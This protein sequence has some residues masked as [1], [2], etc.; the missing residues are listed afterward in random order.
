[1]VVCMNVA[2]YLRQSF[3]RY[4]DELAVTRQLEDCEKLA[5]KLGKVVDVYEDNDTSAS[6]RDV[7]RPEYNRLL[8][9]FEDGR[10]TALVCWDLDRLTRQPRQLEDW[11]D[12]AEERGLKLVTAN[13]EADLS[14]DGGRMYAR[15]KAAVAR[16]EIERKSKRQVSRYQQDASRGVHHWTTRPFGYELDGTLREA[17]ADAVKKAFTDTLA[18]VTRSE[19]AREWNAAGFVGPRDGRPWKPEGVRFQLRAARN[20]G[21]REYKGK[22][23]G[24]GTWTAVVDVDTWRG[25]QAVL[26]GATA[27]RTGGREFTTLLSHLATCAKCGGKVMGGARDK[28][29][30]DRY[31][32]QKNYCV[33]VPRAE[34]DAYVWDHVV[35]E[36]LPNRLD[37]W[38]GATVDVDRQVQLNGRLAEIDAKERELGPAF[39][40][41]LVTLSQMT[42][43][44]AAF[45][46]ERE[47]IAAELAK[48]VSV[49]PPITFIDDATGT[50]FAY[51][52]L[53]A[54]TDLTL[55]QRR[56]MVRDLT[57]SIVIAPQ[58]H[59]GFPVVPYS[60]ADRITITPR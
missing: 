19:I 6:K 14:T 40:S 53:S 21:L 1:M 8:Q 57:K 29:G 20:A 51:V 48:L 28:K 36:L 24:T 16:G 35:R 58:G 5:T 50:P 7:V 22:V 39:A 26:D 44:N 45:T 60:P 23:V 56:A 32:C 31:A 52:H 43:A 11:I 34:T 9:D 38:K 12:R 47:E 15:I 10:F 49:R 3:D 13:G 37:V 54:Y 33:N 18:G 25:V 2:I 46:T 59:K 4:G 55:S 42:S 30:V 41:G 17:E 27:P